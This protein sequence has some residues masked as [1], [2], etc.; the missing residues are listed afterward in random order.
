MTAAV[1]AIAGIGLL[2]R[3]QLALSTDGTNDVTTWCA[4]ADAIQEKGIFS[5]YGITEWVGVPGLRFNHSPPIAW[6]LALVPAIQELTHQGCP[7]LIRLPAS[8]ADFVTTI[9]VW[10]LVAHHWGAQRALISSALIALNPVLIL[11]SGFH[12]NTDPVFLSFLVGSL[13]ALSR[14]RIPLAALC[15]GMALNVKIVPIILFPFMTL[16]PSSK[17]D[18]VRFG[19]WAAV[20]VGIGWLPHLLSTPID[21]FQQIFPYAGWKGA[22]GLSEIV[23]GSYQPAPRFALEGMLFAPVILAAGYILAQP[24]PERAEPA[25]SLSQLFIIL[26]ALTPGFGVQYLAW[27]VP[28]LALVSVRLSVAYAALAGSFLYLTY[29]HWSGGDALG[30]AN[31][32]NVPA[33]QLWTTPGLILKW[34]TWLFLFGLA[35]RALGELGE[36]L[37]RGRMAVL[38]PR[39]RVLALT[40]AAAFSL[41]ALMAGGL[42]YFNYQIVYG[43]FGWSL[44]EGAF[45]LNYLLFGVLAVGCLA[46][47][48]AFTAGDRLLAIFDRLSTLSPRGVT[49][50][51]TGAIV[52]IFALITLA[53]TVLLHNVAI[54]DDENVYIFM[55][56]MLAGGRIYVPSLPEALRP[57]FDNP[58][59]INNGKW[60]GMFFPGHAAALAMGQWINGLRW[61]PTVAATLTALLAF[62]IARRI[63][64]QRTA[65]LTVGLLACSPFFLL[66]SATLL[67]HSTVA[68]LLLAFV[69]STLRAHEAP[70]APRWWLA[71]GVALGWAALT[72][73]VS[74]AAFALP[75]LVWLAVHARAADGGRRRF[76]GGAILA[77]VGLATLAIFCAYNIVLAGAPFVRSYYAF[78][79]YLQYLSAPF[80]LPQIHELGSTIARLNF[81][82]LGWPVSL[83]FLPFFRRSA[84]GLTM[85][86][87]GAGVVLAY[88]LIAGPSIDVAGPVQYA[89]LAAPLVM[90]SASG[91]DQIIE[92]VRGQT[93]RAGVGGFTLG[94][95]LGGILCAAI[96]FV[97]IH[98]SSLRTMSAF[99]RAPY[100]LAEEPGLDN[101]VIF[102]Q[103]LPAFYAPTGAW[104]HSHR[105]NS[106]DLTDRVLFVRDLGPDKD[107]ELIRYLPDRA[108]YLLSMQGSE[109]TLVPLKP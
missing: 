57:F 29:L 45:L 3:I 28:F 22:W 92:R 81:W 19:L 34:L 70:G 30:Y 59:M 83:A 91:I 38:T 94:A 90:L 104:V 89:E 63:F 13:L 96:A 47:A 5:I 16:W 27:L 52:A 44:P 74:A 77:V 4:F 26:L 48:V 8:V 17:R 64:G 54:T 61:V 1:W 86:L 2:L 43:R 18:R 53:R 12:G 75:W 23:Y 62:L 101:A 11:L 15:Y 33:Q 106:P 32:W 10:K 102:V 69:Y 84:E 78:T 51:T 80:P 99:V 24:L 14:G 71:A 21:L 31:V 107:E 37:Y 20:A 50:I 46:A 25:R 88:A 85:L 66:S 73:P 79:P 98:A 6:A 76:A 36:R 68:L 40:L 93:G 87:A 41:A 100:D 105:N 65:L 97:P 82:L 67:P 60:Y 109:L 49:L 103:S 35:L 42:V 39:A 56:R 7:L 55:A 58:L 95:V 108:P 72:R 9:L